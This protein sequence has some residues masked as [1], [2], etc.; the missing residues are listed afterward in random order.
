LKKL[1]FHGLPF[2]TYHKHAF[3]FLGAAEVEVDDLLVPTCVLE[4]HAAALK[5]MKH[6]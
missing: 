1:N 4:L 3:F 2:E 5:P 6:K